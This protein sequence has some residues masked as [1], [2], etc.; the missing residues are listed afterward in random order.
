MVGI[1]ATSFIVI[2]GAAGSAIGFALHGT[3]GNF[4]GGVLILMF[5][6]YKIGDV[7][8]TQGKTGYVKEIQY[9]HTVL[10]TPKGETIILPNGAVSNGTITNYMH[11]GRAL[12]EIPVDLAG[13][14]NL[15]DLRKLLFP[16]IA[17]DE[18]ILTDPQPSIGILA[19][20]PGT[21]SVAFR[22]FTLPQNQVPVTEKMIETIKTE[23]EKNQFA[24]PVPHSFV[25]T[26]SENL[27]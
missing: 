4:S 24:D 17:Q 19:L 10:N 23:L 27:N 3:L 22:A 7:I 26:I 13:K 8:E 20:K 15:Q 25:H 11:L 16:V 14:T 6:P 21:I 18:R 5:K 2:V 9:F 1:Q 12:V